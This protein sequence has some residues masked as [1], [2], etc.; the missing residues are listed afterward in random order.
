LG[1]EFTST[2]TTAAGAALEP[3]IE[4]GG[5]VVFEAEDYDARVDVGG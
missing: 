3:L 2:F 1:A 4:S 5:L